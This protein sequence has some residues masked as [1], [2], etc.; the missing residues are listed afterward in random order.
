VPFIPDQQVLIGSERLDAAS[1]SVAASLNNLAFL[2]HG[3]V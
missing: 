3:A 1:A 2:Y